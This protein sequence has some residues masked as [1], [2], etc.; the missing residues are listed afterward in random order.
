MEL[1]VWQDAH[2]RLVS[3]LAPDGGTTGHRNITITLC[4]QP[5]PCFRLLPV[6]QIEKAAMTVN[7]RDFNRQR[8]HLVEKLLSNEN[9]EEE[10]KQGVLECKLAN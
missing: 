2:R 5:V 10:G 8:Q 3:S 9:S 6:T 4:Y 7:G 1:D